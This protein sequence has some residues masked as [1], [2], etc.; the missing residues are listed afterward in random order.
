[1]FSMTVNQAAPYCSFNTVIGGKEHNIA[2]PASPGDSLPK[3]I[4]LPSILL[5]I[6]SNSG[7]KLQSHPSRDDGM[8]LYF[9]ATHSG[10][11]QFGP[12]EPALHATLA[13][14]LSPELLPLTTPLALPVVLV[15]VVKTP[16][17]VHSS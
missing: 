7:G 3:M 14:A 16:L 11:V 1:V 5:L 6:P 17:P 13:L 15:Q 2:P 4:S 8:G 10:S 12:D 9:P